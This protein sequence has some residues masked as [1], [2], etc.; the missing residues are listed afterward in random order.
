MA[1]K[2]SNTLNEPS[3]NILDVP[4]NFFEKQI[5]HKIFNIQYYIKDFANYY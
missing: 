3:P 1:E 2:V 4:D 5:N